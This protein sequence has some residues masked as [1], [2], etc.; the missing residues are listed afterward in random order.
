MPCIFISTTFYV[1]IF[2]NEMDSSFFLKSYHSVYLSS[3]S[4]KPSTDAAFP[5]SMPS[6][7]RLLLLR[8]LGLASTTWREVKALSK[9]ASDRMRELSKVKKAF[10]EASA[11]VEHR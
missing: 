6:L 7:C 4:D 8:E 5:F 1:K 11:K 10:E 9:K 2:I 3:L